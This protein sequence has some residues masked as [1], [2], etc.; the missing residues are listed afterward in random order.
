M[1][2]LDRTS[3]HMLRAELEAALKTVAAK[4]GVDFSV[5]IIRY[6]SATARCKI[7]GV[8]R[9]AAGTSTAVPTNPALVALKR[10][11]RMVGLDET[12]NY[13]SSTLGVVKVVGYK[14]R[15]YKYPYI[16]QMASNGRRY[17]VTANTIQAMVREGPVA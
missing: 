14:P 10:Q 3:I 4:T 6:D 8:V 1:K 12:K 15:S 17:K 13:R 9:G 2:S 16:V 11:A 5:G 7:E